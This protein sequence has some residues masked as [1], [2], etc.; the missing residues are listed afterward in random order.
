MDFALTD[1]Q[2]EHRDHVRKFAREVI[3][4][5]ARKHDEEESTP[6][7]VMKEARKWGLQG[8]EHMQLMGADPGGQLGVITA[9]ELHW[10]CAGIALATQGSGLAAAGIAA[11]G[12]T[13]ARTSSSAEARLL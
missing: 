7:E 12:V 2:R 11:S 13:T 3:R 1:Q 9:E 8:L 10:G 6:W 5:V 4:P